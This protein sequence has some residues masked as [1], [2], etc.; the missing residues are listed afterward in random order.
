[1]E[2]ELSLN[3]FRAILIYTFHTREARFTHKEAEENPRNKIY[4]TLGLFKMKHVQKSQDGKLF[5]IIQLYM[6]FD[7]CFNNAV[8]LMLLVD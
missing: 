4:K 5:I 7:K 2:E 1:M 6:T 3:I 8:F